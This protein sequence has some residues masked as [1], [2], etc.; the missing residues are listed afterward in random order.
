[1]FAEG[2]KHFRRNFAPPMTREI[3]RQLEQLLDQFGEKQ[4]LNPLVT[5]CKWNDWQCVANAIQRIARK[6]MTARVKRR[7]KLQ[8]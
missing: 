8:P 4:V 2:R 7:V 1:V 6:D 3:E 5:K